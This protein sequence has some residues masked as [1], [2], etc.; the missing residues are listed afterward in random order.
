MR[1]NNESFLLAKNIP[2]RLG[3]RAA[4]TTEN[5]RISKKC[6]TVGSGN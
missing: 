4:V 5:T 1:F 3:L 6:K 2:L